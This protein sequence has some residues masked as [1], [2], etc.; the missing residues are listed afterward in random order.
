MK[1]TM[2]RM[3]VFFVTWNGCTVNSLLIKENYTCAM[4]AL[5]SIKNTNLPA[6]FLQ[7]KA[8]FFACAI[9]ASFYSLPG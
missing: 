1:D 8:T 7:Q 2:S 4:I 9:Y 6:H 3:K 5:V